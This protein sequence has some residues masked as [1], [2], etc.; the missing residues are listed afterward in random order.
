M[1]K[2]TGEDF[3]L[4]VGSKKTKATKTN[5]RKHKGSKFLVSYILPLVLYLVLMVFISSQSKGSFMTGGL[6]LS[7]LHVIEYFVLSTLMLRI[8]IHLG[9]KDHFIA[10]VLIA[11]LI[12][13]V[14]ELYQSTVP[15]RTASMLDI[16]FD[17]AGAS[18]ILFF[19][20]FPRLLF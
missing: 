10:A 5:L 1:V 7:F 13:V 11:L 20:R 19:R 4:H 18:L 16:L 12:G 8:L 15:S 2:R 9:T 6:D 14:D 17:G 3:A